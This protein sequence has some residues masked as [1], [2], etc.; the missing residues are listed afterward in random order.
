MKLLKNLNLIQ[1]GQ[2]SFIEEFKLSPMPVQGLILPAVRILMAAKQSMPSKM[3][4]CS[5][6]MFMLF[7]LAT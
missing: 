1:V 5:V 2:I 3:L 6:E 4:Y 7:T